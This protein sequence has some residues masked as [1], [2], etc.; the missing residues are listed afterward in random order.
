MFLDDIFV[1]PA[2]RKRG[3]GKALLA[4]VAKI[5]WEEDYFCVRWEVLDWNTEAIAFFQNHGAV[6]L[7][8]WKSGLLVGDTLESM[9]KESQ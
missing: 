2:Y 6:F 8:E 4:R 9:A 5:A 3:I 1:R 7:D